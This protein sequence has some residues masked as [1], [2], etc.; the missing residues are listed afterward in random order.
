MIASAVYALAMAEN[1]VPRFAATDMPA[2]APP[3]AP[4]STAVPRETPP[5][6]AAKRSG[7]N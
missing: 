5:A 7:N 3:P 4:G 1:L 2:P 6:K